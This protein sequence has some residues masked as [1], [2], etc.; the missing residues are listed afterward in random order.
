[1]TFC[2]NSGDWD[3]SEAIERSGDLDRHRACMAAHA[4][5]YINTNRL[6]GYLASLDGATVGW[7]NA[8]AKTDF[9]RFDSGWVDGVSDFIMADPAPN[10][11]AVTC[12]LIDPAHRGQGIAT[13]LL[14]HAVADA[15][16][17]GFTSI[18]GYPRSHNE[19]DPFDFTGPMT[20]YVRSGFTAVN[21][22]PGATIM[23]RLLAQD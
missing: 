3:S 21:Q 8:A 13:A 11:F 6:N 20:M 1:M 23:R 12:F 15:R 7:C 16:R 9:Q 2:L 17:R 19:T 4:T 5:D 14:N 10:A 22:S 18:E